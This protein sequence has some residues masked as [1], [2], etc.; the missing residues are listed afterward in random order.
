MD[1]LSSTLQPYK[2]AVGSVASVV[3]IGQF[4]SGAFICHDIYKKK[5][6]DGISALPFI[7][8]TIMYVSQ[9]YKTVS[10]KRISSTVVS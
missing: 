6:T 1:T 3:T 9:K 8:G 7:G 2:D 5:Q 4:F 10:H